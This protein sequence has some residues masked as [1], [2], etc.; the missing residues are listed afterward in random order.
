MP[1][2]TLTQTFQSELSKLNIN[3]YFSDNTEKVA[4]FKRTLFDLFTSR[5]D[6]QE[7]PIDSVL[8]S[9]K[10]VAMLNL[11]LG[12]DV[13]IILR[14]GRKGERPKAKAEINY[15]GYITLTSRAGIVCRANAVYAN[16][17]FDADLAEGAISHKPNLLEERGDVIGYYAIVDYQGQRVID[18][19]SQKEL[20]KWKKTY[21]GEFPS[22]A[23][24]K[25]ETEMAKKTILKRT[26][27]PYLYASGHGALIEATALD[28]DTETNGGQTL[29]ADMSTKPK[30]D[31]S[32]ISVDVSSLRALPG[33]EEVAKPQTA[34]EPKTAPVTAS[35]TV[36][37]EGDQSKNR[38]AQLKKDETTGQ[39]PDNTSAIT[40]DGSLIEARIK[41]TIA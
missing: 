6:L 20:Q 3:S 7:C 40:A 29:E 36:V 4:K 13:D 23:W 9:A 5:P 10:K 1:D 33:R 30:T 16:D 31:V 12:G 21:L 39:Q 19:L 14:S 2:L 11:T 35:E 17:I 18:V 34:E 24:R 22:P 15:K 26:I 37:R 27:K 38:V 32:S 25:S 8:D 41:P 28:N